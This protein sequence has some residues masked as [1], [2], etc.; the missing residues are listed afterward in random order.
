MASM[1]T[2]NPALEQSALDLIW[3]V[4]QYL[5]MKV[6]SHDA[7]IGE[8][9]SKSLSCFECQVNECLTNSFRQN[10]CIWCSWSSSI[11][12]WEI[13]YMISSKDANRLTYDCCLHSDLRRKV[14][15]Q[16]LRP[17]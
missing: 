10:H 16:S 13:P 11:L 17:N 2:G 12:Y 6:S 15:Y 3:G 4:S 1:S 9:K 5:A 8:R 14:S 7:M